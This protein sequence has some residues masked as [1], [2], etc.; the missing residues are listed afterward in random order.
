MYDLT[1]TLR[2]F[3][4]DWHQ[5]RSRLTTAEH[6]GAV[7]QSS[8]ANMEPLW[9]QETRRDKGDMCSPSAASRP[10]LKGTVPPGGAHSHPKACLERWTG[11]YAAKWHVWCGFIWRA[12]AAA[13]SSVPELTW[14]QT[15]TTF[16]FK[17]FKPFK[18]TRIL[19]KV[20]ESD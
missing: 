10:A 19:E 5:A 18:Q 14:R 8:A 16:T 4:A 3:Q 17:D 11:G 12:A 6:M 2:K 9:Q 20:T 13:G 1:L 7:K 15:Q